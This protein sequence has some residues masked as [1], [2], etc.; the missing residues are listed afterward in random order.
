MNRTAE[1][2]E[3]LRTALA[4]DPEADGDRLLISF[5]EGRGFDSPARSAVNLRLLAATF[6]AACLLNVALT[7]LATPQPD[8]ALNSLERLVAIVQ[9]DDLVAVCTRKDSLAQLLTVC[10]SSP[11]LAGILCRAP[12]YFTDLFIHRQ[13]DVKRDEEGTLA[14]LRALIAPEAD[15]HA[16]LPLLRQFKY[17]EI[18]RI[19]ARD[20]NG[21]APLKEVTAELTFL[22]SATLQ[23]AYEAARRS[24]VAEHGLPLMETPG[25]MREADLT[26]LG[27]GKLGGKELNFSSDIDIVYFYSSDRGETSGVPDGSG[28]TK[29]K[30]SLHTF[31]TK[32]AEMVTRAISQVTGDGFVFRVDL[33]LRPEGKSGDMAV[34]LRSAEIYYESWGQSWERA[35]ML[36]ARP[37]AGNRDL[38]EQF[39][40]LIEPFVYRKYLDYNLIDDIMA[41]KKK[42][43]ASLA[44]EREGEYNIKLGRGGIREIE[45][46]I[47]AL[48]LV[49]AGKNPALRVKNTIAA[50]AA[51]R[52]ARLIKEA[53]CGALHEAYC[54]LRTVE[55][56][57]Q[58]VQ[59]R[60]THSLP[61]QDEEMLA[62]SRRCGFLRQNGLER[63]RNTLEGHRRRVSAI[64]GD[65]FL[66][67]DERLKEDV[68]P[69]IYF[70]F[71]RAASPDLIR[72]MLAER[73][74][75]RIDA[76]YENLLILRDGP[77]KARLTE[78]ARRQLE[79][80]APLLLG[81]IF[82]SP[83]PDMAL[84]N[85]ERF[86]CSVGPRSTF[87]ALLAENRQILKLVVSLF[88]MSEFL[89]KIFISHPELL[90]SMVARASSTYFK[91]CR[92]MEVELTNL[93]DQ[94]DDFEERLDVL[95]RYRHEEVLRIGMNDIY[96]K[97]GQTEIATQLT[98]LAEVCLTAAYRM[99]QTELARFGRPICRDAIS[100]EEEAHLAIIG[101]GK[102]GGYE[103]NYHSDLDII[104][105][106]DRQGMTDGEKRI[107]NHEYFAKLGQ[108]IISILTTQTREGYVFKI[109]T[110]L[111]PSGNAGP[112][113]TSLDSFKNYHRQESQ[114][115]ERQAL[116][117]ARVVLGEES[118]RDSIEE[119][120]RHA[121]YGSA[122]GTETRQ[123]IH[124][125][126][127]RMETEIARESAGSYNIKTGRGGMVDVEFIVQYL[128]LQHGKYFPE[129]RSANTLTALKAMNAC[130]VLSTDDTSM[131]QNGYK[132]LRRLENRLRI[133]HD[134]SMNDLGGPPEYLDKLARR[135]GYDPKLRNPGS[136]LMHDYEEC[137]GMV[138]RVYE[139][140]LAT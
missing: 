11:F 72:D 67:R 128:Q 62:L 12:S 136:T 60:Q 10:G 42:I 113:V 123:E 124:R 85:M 110:R 96:G 90:D 87:Y 118:L 73:R 111:R 112:L 78:R 14:S 77:P 131:L 66:S 133:V 122:A 127:M 89:S 76:A 63:F 30:L 106:Y 1:L 98:W 27:M 86:L 9:R 43:D 75:E 103:L 36:K 46:F 109:D 130:G 80:I 58:V 37:V 99:A 45:F 16:I 25:G 117:K 59:E 108:K 2:A 101:M 28:G 120:V 19:A 61:K 129:I 26:V 134:Y 20:L 31:F 95:R 35:A 13:I 18:L 23:V 100:G 116:T 71:D 22:A 119:I 65:L 84:V 24:L 21:L 38:G 48:Q 54:F 5:L 49:Y 126:R 121:V 132:F 125:L 17:R 51:L 29:G 4:V 7:S 105:V 102:M 107:T 8:M 64:Y 114:V 115:W 15:Y 135:I 88:G 47:Q 33:G 137:T 91:E 92:E 52:D 57:I 140:I 34:S 79:K 41:M 83:D 70:F 39:L 50:L 97:L 40:A 6:P 44:R 32:L 74:F 94:A 53:D 138:R 56:R 93:L 68:R 82:A 104:Y 139:R 69:E 81:E 55:H 3:E